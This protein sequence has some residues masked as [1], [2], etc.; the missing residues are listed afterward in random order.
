[1]LLLALRRV[2]NASDIGTERVAESRLLPFQDAELTVDL[3]LSLLDT[4]ELRA[5]SRRCS[6]AVAFGDRLGLGQR[7][8][9][10]GDLLLDPRDV[11]ILI[12][13][14]AAQR[15][16]L[17]LEPGKAFSR[18]FG[19]PFPRLGDG[20]GPLP[21]ERV[22]TLPKARLAITVQTQLPRESIDGA[23]IG[24]GLLWEL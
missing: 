16:K 11:G 18:P 14:G 20:F 2:L 22:A 8:L 1:E 23:Q 9:E 12:A 17:D 3:C 15:P 7:A 13:V 24:V 4:E 10:R 5:Q 6:L 19:S 21:I